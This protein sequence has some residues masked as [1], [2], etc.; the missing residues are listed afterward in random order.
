MADA[1]TTT[2]ANYYVPSGKTTALFNAYETSISAY[3]NAQAAADYLSGFYQSTDDGTA[4]PAPDIAL[5]TGWSDDTQTQLISI[6]LEYMPF[7]YRHAPVRE[8]IRTD[9]HFAQTNHFRI[10]PNAVNYPAN[11]STYLRLQ[12]A[13]TI[14]QQDPTEH[15]VKTVLTDQYYGPC[16]LSVCRETSYRNLEFYTQGTALFTIESGASPV[17]QYQV[18][19]NPLSNPLTTYTGT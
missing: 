11:H 9:K 8:I 14:L 7:P 13:E 15:G 4:F 6:L 3:T 18:N 2:S 19:G 5:I 12:R 1:Y 16:E 17:T 10:Q